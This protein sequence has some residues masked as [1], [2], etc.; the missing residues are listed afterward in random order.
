MKNEKPVYVREYNDRPQKIEISD[1]KNLKVGKSLDFK[2]R[3]VKIKSVFIGKKV[4]QLQVT[5]V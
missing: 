2:G 3:D 5:E 4:I 1:I